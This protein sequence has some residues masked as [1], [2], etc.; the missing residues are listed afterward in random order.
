MRVTLSPRTGS[1]TSPAIFD[2]AGPSNAEL[3]WE[4]CLQ[5]FVIYYIDGVTC[6]FALH[7]CVL[8]IIIEVL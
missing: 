4:Y 7:T 6:L 5:S 8:L 3:N 1:D 2:Q